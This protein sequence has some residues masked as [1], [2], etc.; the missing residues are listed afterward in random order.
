MKV[1]TGNQI[2]FDSFSPL[3]TY[4]SAIIDGKDYYVMVRDLEMEHGLRTTVLHSE[5]VEIVNRCDCC[6]RFDQ[7][8][9]VCFSIVEAIEK[10]WFLAKDIYEEW[11]KSA[12]S[13]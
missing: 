1:A 6:G 10:G 12:K 4:G 9:E 2:R 8:P 7:R 11:A 3:W 5:R 13:K